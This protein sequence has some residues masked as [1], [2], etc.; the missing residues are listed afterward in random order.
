MRWWLWAGWRR[1]PTEII[2]ADETRARTSTYIERPPVLFAHDFTGTGLVA[3]V[4]WQL[5]PTTMGIYLV[6]QRV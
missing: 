6:Y 2:I 1:S 4:R 5:V 3:G